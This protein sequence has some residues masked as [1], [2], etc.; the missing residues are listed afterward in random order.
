MAAML[1]EGLISHKGVLAPE[2]CVDPLEF[3]ARMEKLEP[4]SA[5]ALEVEILELE[6]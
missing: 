2:A 6:M 4:D 5:K 1:L 3:S